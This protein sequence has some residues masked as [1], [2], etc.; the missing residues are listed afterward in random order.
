[1]LNPVTSQSINSPAIV[2]HKIAQ[3]YRIHWFLGLR[4]AELFILDRAGALEYTKSELKIADIKKRRLELESVELLK[5]A[6]C[7]IDD[8]R[9][10][11]ALDM[12]EKQIHI[13]N[14]NRQIE[15]TEYQ[16]RDAFAELREADRMRSMITRDH[17]EEIENMSFEELQDA[18]G[19][20]CI[21]AKQ[22]DSLC[23]EVMALS[24]GRPIAEI[25]NSVETGRSDSVLSS[26][27][28]T[29]KSMSEFPNLIMKSLPSK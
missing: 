5:I 6:N 4:Q 14:L 25:L 17:A 26:A 29:Y 21:E 9:G 23:I 15:K 7:P 27:I 11:A 12:E 18:F 24:V 13:N 28:D 8:R 1:M 3:E 22:A 10:L 20:E 2:Q 19:V 16:I